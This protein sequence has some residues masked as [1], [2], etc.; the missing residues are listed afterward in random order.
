M[1][2]VGGFEKQKLSESLE[3]FENIPNLRIALPFLE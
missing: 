2:N 3:K 1:Q